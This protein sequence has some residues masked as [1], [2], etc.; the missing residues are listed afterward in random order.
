MLK[1]SKSGE[2]V[3]EAVNPVSELQ[4]IAQRLQLR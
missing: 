3:I 2:N 1:F 4:G